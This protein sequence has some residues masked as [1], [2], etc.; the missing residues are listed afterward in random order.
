MKLIACAVFDSAVNAFMRPFFVPH[1]GHA[2]RSFTDE[3]NG[4]SGE[5]GP[6]AQHPD[7]YTL[8]CVGT[9]EEETGVFEQETAPQ[10]LVRGK[11][12]VS[13]Q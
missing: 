12:I 8:Y 3:I 13:K 10:V 2:L 1:Q 5:K 7:D 11:D 4:V 9:F 6:L